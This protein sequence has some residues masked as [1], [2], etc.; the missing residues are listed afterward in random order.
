[1]IK[2]RKEIININLEDYFASKQID[3]ANYLTDD[4]FE[5][6]QGL[7]KKVALLKG[8]EEKCLK[9]KQQ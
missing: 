5:T 3:C 8:E 4:E 2:K 1:M 9:K 6:L 7:H